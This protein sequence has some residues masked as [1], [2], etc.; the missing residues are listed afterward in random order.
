MQTW[1]DD[2]DQFAFVPSEAI[3]GDLV[4]LRAEMDCLVALS[5]CPG[6]SSH[7]RATGIYVSIDGPPSASG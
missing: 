6:G 1:I 4:E 5:A 2:N 7:A 3:E